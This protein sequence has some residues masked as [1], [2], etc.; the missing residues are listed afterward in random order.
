MRCNPIP[1][2]SLYLYLVGAVCVLLW[3]DCRP[4]RQSKNE[5]R[6]AFTTSGELE[7]KHHQWQSTYLTRCAS[8]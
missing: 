3:R 7:Q 6:A 4:G 2:G 5:L 1:I 8:L